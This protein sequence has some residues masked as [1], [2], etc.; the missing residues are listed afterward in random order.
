MWQFLGTINK[1]D[2]DD[3]VNGTLTIPEGIEKLSVV[4]THYPNID[5]LNKVKKIVLPKSFKN[6]DGVFRMFKNLEEV[7]LEN[8]ETISR[9]AISYEL[10]LKE[11]NLTSLKKIAFDS[12]FTILDN[13][14]KIIIDKNFG[15]IKIT[16]YCFDADALGVIR[17]VVAFKE[18]SYY[19]GPKKQI[20][21]PY[22]ING[23]NIAVLCTSYYNV[24]LSDD[25][26]NKEELEK[27][28]NYSSK[29][30]ELKKALYHYNLI[31]DSLDNLNC[32]DR[33]QE[34]YQLNEYIKATENV[35]TKYI[36]EY[37]DFKNLDENNYAIDLIKEI[38]SSIKSITKKINQKMNNEYN[39]S[40]QYVKGLKKLLNK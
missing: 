8:V 26:E 19:A 3:I 2:E 9:E 36:S 25:E 31:Y 17:T 7:N 27:Y 32:E 30:S 28:L 16:N 4:L 34:Y 1:I 37:D 18:N 24:S 23:R 15:K 13:S 20:I 5:I 35:L 11:A 40:Q 21:C 29:L 12:L 33:I 38:S 14:Q 22:K 39:I 10:K 6:L